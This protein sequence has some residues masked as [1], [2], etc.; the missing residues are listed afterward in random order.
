MVVAEP[1]QR[2]VVQLGEPDLLSREKL[3]RTLNVLLEMPYK[4]TPIPYFARLFAVSASSLVP[5]GF[6]SKE[7]F[8]VAEATYEYLKGHRLII[9]GVTSR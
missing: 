7:L 6:C 5:D 9:D 2:H 3:A 8:Q 1:V 4:G